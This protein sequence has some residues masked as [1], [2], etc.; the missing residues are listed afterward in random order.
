MNTT[1]LNTFRITALNGRSNLSQLGQS[2][3]NV[4]GQIGVDEMVW[5]DSGTIATFQD[6]P[7]LITLLNSGRDGIACSFV[8]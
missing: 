5:S 8:A 3:D 1:T 2:N 7:S 4:G 6:S